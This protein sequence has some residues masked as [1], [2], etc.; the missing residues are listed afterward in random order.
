MGS[1]LRKVNHSG[2]TISAVKWFQTVVNNQK[3]QRVREADDTSGAA[4]DT[5]DLPQRCP[6]CLEPIVALIT[7]SV[8]SSGGIN[9]F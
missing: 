2:D 5:Q 4:A 7:F 3:S 9:R 6:A 1:K 8:V